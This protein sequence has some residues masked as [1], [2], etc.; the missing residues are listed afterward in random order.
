MYTN[1]AILFHTCILCGVVVCAS[2]AA[3]DNAVKADLSQP[4]ADSLA[5]IDHV[6]QELARKSAE[7][8]FDTEKQARD[9][10]EAAL[11]DIRQHLKVEIDGVFYNI[12][13]A[14]DKAGIDESP[15]TGIKIRLLHQAAS[16]SKASHVFK[17]VE[18]ILASKAVSTIVKE[19]I[20]SFILS[21]YGLLNEWDQT[22]WVRLFSDAISIEGGGKFTLAYAFQVDPQT[23]INVYLR[24]QRDAAAAKE[25]RK[26]IWSTH[27][28]GNVVWQYD[29]GW[30]NKVTAAE[31]SQ[32]RE[33]LQ[34]LASSEDWAV[35]CYTI[36]TMNKYGR[37]FDNSVITD[38]LDDDQS[39]I[40]A[41][42]QKA[43]ERQANH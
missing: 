41:T 32:S 36:A 2:H 28:I 5:Y 29:N 38:L 25:T 9:A 1:M 24:T 27:I 15:A 43:V 26:I 12:A 35:R 42:A 13:I 33:N 39:V 6:A 10:V 31:L 4:S 34:A 21:K 8:A 17:V 40:R 19:E 23:A 14:L 20:Q 30:H 22:G 37:L 7:G 11:D 3:A 18:H 16:R